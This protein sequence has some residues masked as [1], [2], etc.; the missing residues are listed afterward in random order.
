MCN[1]R[2]RR[3]FMFDSLT[4][5]R[6]LVPKAVWG[7][8]RSKLASKTLKTKRIDKSA[9][10]P[11]RVRVCFGFATNFWHS[12]NPSGGSAASEHN[13]ITLRVSSGGQADSSSYQNDMRTRCMGASSY[14]DRLT[15]LLLLPSPMADL[16]KIQ[17]EH[18][19]TSGGTYCCF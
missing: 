15:M 19:E 7:T 11:I 17:Q 10:W 12:S 8:F 3:V 14:L 1:L 2:N 5:C 16:T 13:H 9:C 6:N 4:C 18:P